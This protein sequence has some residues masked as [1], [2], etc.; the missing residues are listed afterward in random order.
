MRVSLP[1]HNLEIANISGCNRKKG[2]MFWVPA[3]VL[4]MTFCGNVWLLVFMHA[5]ML[6]YVHSWVCVCVLTCQRLALSPQGKLS[7]AARCNIGS[8]G[9]CW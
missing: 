1:L 5:C 2:K 6:V 9:Q 7:Q 4:H 3:L 8:W